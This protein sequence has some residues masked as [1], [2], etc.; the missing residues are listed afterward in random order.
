MDWLE[1]LKEWQDLAGATLGGAFALAVALLVAYQAR[2]AEDEAA[3]TLLIGEFLR[4]VSM[5]NAATKSA[6]EHAVP[7]DKRPL[8]LAEHL[9]RYR[10]R[11]SP[12][13]DQSVARLNRYDVPLAAC[14]FLASS[15]IRD[16]EPVLVRLEGD[17]ARLHANLQPLR[18]T[19]TIESEAN[20][21][22]SGYQLISKHSALA[23]KLLDQI[24]LG[25]FPT[26]HQLRRRFY[27]LDWERELDDLLRRGT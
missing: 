13:F 14:L 27:K 8:L 24:V 3:A 11:L 23:I 20:T 25:P 1:A 18:S 10:V 4:I 17:V 6:E 9:C 2:R 16:T 19:Q 5:V 7:E 15:F 26:W 12:L 21:V 22:S